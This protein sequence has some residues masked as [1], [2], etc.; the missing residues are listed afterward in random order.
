MATHAA[1]QQRP[2]AVHCAA[3]P[4]SIMGESC[5]RVS[6]S[7]QSRHDAAPRDDH[8]PAAH[9][10]HTVAL[11]AAKVPAAH[12]V[13]GGHPPAP[14]AL[15]LPA[16]LARPAVPAE[17]ARPW[18][19]ARDCP[20]SGGTEPAGKRLLTLTPSVKTAWVIRAPPGGTRPGTAGS[21]ALRKRTAT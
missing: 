17:Q 5:D 2:H 9:V 3:F 20:V 13:H 7:G 19:P 6:C 8:S 11:S 21:V 14:P 15:L 18:L 10:M 4:G 1:V 16:G 12:G